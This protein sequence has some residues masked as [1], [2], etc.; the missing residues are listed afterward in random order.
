MSWGEESDRQ[1]AK[2]KETVLPPGFQEDPQDD[3]RG[4]SLAPPET[5]PVA[6][7]PRSAARQIE[8]ASGREAWDRRLRPRHREVVRQYFDTAN[9]RGR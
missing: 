1:G 6:A 5:D 3:V 7:A 8:A 2:F 9:D 4:V